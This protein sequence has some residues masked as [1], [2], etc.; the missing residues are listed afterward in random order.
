MDGTE[1][2]ITDFLFHWKTAWENTAGRDGDIGTY[3]A[4]YSEGFSGKGFDKK[5]WETDKAAKNKRKAWIKIELSDIRI[6]YPVIDN[7]VVVHFSQSYRS[8]NF[9]DHSVLSLAL[10]K[11][12]SGWKII[13]IQ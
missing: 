9:S 1:Q 7:E 11:E 5:G 2:A 13:G 3:L 4:F 6:P 10:K 12:D 8:S